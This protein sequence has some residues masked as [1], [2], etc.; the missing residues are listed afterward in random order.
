LNTGSFLT[1]GSAH[2]V[3]LGLI[4]GTSVGLVIVARSERGR[5]YLAPIRY[6]LAAMLVGNELIYLIG[7]VATGRWTAAWGLPLQICDLAIF[8]V[9]FSLLK[10]QRFIWE[11]AYF[12]GLGG[13]MQALL[14]PDL[15][16][17]FPDYI[18]FKFFLTHGLI[19]IGIIF[20]AAGL[21]RPIFLSSLKRVFIATNVYAAFIGVVNWLMGTNYLYLCRKP[22]QPS[23]IDVMG[24][25]PVYLLGLEAALVVSLFVYYMPYCLA[26]KA[27]GIRSLE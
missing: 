9:A 11:I 24:P 23:I 26:K 8:A 27:R 2:L 21:G 4:F 7:L 14:T 25:W 10:H 3:T 1:F 18:F 5:T 22:S 17:T 20:L 13:T 15:R 16:V 19:V 6:G 12:W